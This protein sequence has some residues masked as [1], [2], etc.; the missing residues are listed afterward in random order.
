ME[1]SESESTHLSANVQTGLFA[2]V[3][4][5]I[6]SLG[7]GLTEYAKA[8][9]IPPIPA[10]SVPNFIPP[11]CDGRCGLASALPKPFRVVCPC[12]RNALTVQEPSTGD[13]GAVVG[14]PAAK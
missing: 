1:R 4:V 12:C 6:I 5:A 7:F 2:L 9:K 13:I 11:K 3:A 10:P 8:T 14:K